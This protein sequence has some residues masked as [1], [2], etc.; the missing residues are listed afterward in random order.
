MEVV[1]VGDERER[2]EGGGGGSGGGCGE[3]GGAGGGWREGEGGTVVALAQIHAYL[4]YGP[5]HCPGSAV[6]W[7]RSQP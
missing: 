2:Q 6:A 5:S 3:R 1:A 7:P 4:Y